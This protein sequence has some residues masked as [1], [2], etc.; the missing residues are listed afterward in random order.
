MKQP[1][2]KK[3]TKDFEG[4]STIAGAQKTECHPARAVSLSICLTA[5]ISG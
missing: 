2:Q 5:A 1:L 3:K 4:A